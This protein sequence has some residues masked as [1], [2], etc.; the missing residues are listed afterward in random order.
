[1]DPELLEVL[2]NLVSNAVK[3]TPGGGEIKLSAEAAGDQVLVKVADNG[4]G[5]TPDDA[6][7]IFQR[8]YRVKDEHTRHIV[9]TGLGLD[10]VKRVVEKHGGTISVDSAP[11]Q[12]STFT[13]A[14]PTAAAAAADQA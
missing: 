11:G 8:F 4:L 14:L 2:V 12:G 5:L 7:R 9:G 6:K 3:Y 13:V 1:M 10:I